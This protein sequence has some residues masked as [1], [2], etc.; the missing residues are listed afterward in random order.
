MS[1]TK[2]N[3]RHSVWNGSLVTTRSP[4]LLE[5]GESTISEN[6]DKR[7]PG[8]LKRRGGWTELNGMP[9][10]DAAYNEV[11]GL[12]YYSVALGFRPEGH[13]DDNYSRVIAVVGEH[14]YHA[15]ENQGIPG[16]PHDPQGLVR[17]DTWEQ[18]DG[19]TSGDS[20][21]GTDSPMDFNVIRPMMVQLDRK[22]YIIYS[23]GGQGGYN[24]GTIAGDIASW[25]SV[26][27]VRK[28][29]ASPRASKVVVYGSQL[30]VA[31]NAT[32]EN[33]IYWSGVQGLSGP[34]TWPALNFADLDEGDGDIIIGLAALHNT[35]IVFKKNSVWRITG[36]FPDDAALDD[37]NVAIIKMAG[38]MPGAWATRSIVSTGAEIIW[39]SDQGIYSF[40]GQS[41]K[42]LTKD[43]RDL[44]I[45]KDNENKSGSLQGDQSALG[46]LINQKEYVCFFYHRPTK[47]T[48]QRIAVSI[49][50]D[51]G[52]I[53][54]WTGSLA[55]ATAYCRVNEANLFGFDDGVVGTTEYSYSDNGDNIPWRYRTG[56]INIGPLNELKITRWAT[57]L[58]KP[59]TEEVTIQT[60]EDLKS[61]S[62]KGK[63]S[64]NLTNY[65][66]L[67][68]VTRRKNLTNM[69]RVFQIEITGDGSDHTQSPE[70]YEVVLE[71]E[72]K[73]L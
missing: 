2:L 70:L 24:A 54:K 56:Q 57:I 14:V 65:E 16:D 8:V 58:A 67:P 12:G 48:L 71:Y 55:L 46:Y 39:L 33:R 49:N 69:G 30:V 19:N 9:I 17:V 18:I 4:L 51:T 63:V 53:T 62:N 21:L 72:R 5:A 45:G 15:E 23:F 66:G 59:T 35:L 47:L 68:F 32:N 10:V 28:V 11:S 52:A 20:L 34:D 37:G 44:F 26:N 73:S 29:S 1:R 36:Y 22:L 43:C 64:V 6:V 50:L 41:F 27:F 25:D 40:N 61:T 60:I 31:G 3:H 7:Y 13:D 42:E 38:E